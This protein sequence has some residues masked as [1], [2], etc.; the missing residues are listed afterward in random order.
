MV[1]L[2]ICSNHC[3][4]VF[5]CLGFF[6]PPPNFHNQSSTQSSF[7]DCLSKLVLF[8]KRKINPSFSRVL[9]MWQNRVSGFWSFNVGLRFLREYCVS[10]PIVYRRCETDTVF[11][12]W[13]VN[14]SI[15]FLKFQMTVFNRVQLT[16]CAPLVFC[17]FI[18]KPCHFLSQVNLSF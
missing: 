12:F 6:A 9:S 18:F 4:L 16:S 3:C 13:T 8:Q 14:L 5:I 1:V 17:F 10:W 2:P 7:H 11:H 15:S